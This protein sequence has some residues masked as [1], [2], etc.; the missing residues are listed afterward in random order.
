VTDEA[1]DDKKAPEPTHAMELDDASRADE[2]VDLSEETGGSLDLAGS[3]EHTSDALYILR[4]S[5]VLEELATALD[6]SRIEL[7]E[8]S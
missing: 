5:S 2:P 4:E 1:H 8:E 3:P 6:K 7:K